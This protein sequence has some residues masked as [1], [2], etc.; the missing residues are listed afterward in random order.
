MTEHNL[1]KATMCTVRFH[2]YGEPADV[3]RM[4]DTMLPGPGPNRIRVRVIACGLNPADWALCRGLFPGNLPR[5]IGLDVSGAIDA[6][7]EGVVDVGVGD[8]VLGVADYAG[9]A[10]AGAWSKESAKAPA[11]LRT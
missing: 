7:G 2:Q 6:V 11:R 1:A 5:G 3:L 10:T 8:Q 4:E 9:C